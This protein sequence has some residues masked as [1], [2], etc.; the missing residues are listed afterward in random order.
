MGIVD[1]VMTPVCYAYVDT[2]L[3]QSLSLDLNLVEYLGMH[4]LKILL[5][6]MEFE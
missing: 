2:S 1:N 6:E 3:V 4:L 5:S